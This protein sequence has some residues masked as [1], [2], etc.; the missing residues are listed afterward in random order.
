MSVGASSSE[1]VPRSGAWLTTGS[2]IPDS[3]RSAP[4][5]RS[6]VV[7]TWADGGAFYWFA[8]DGSFAS[9][10]ADPDWPYFQGF[11]PG[12]AGTWAFRDGR[13]R[14]CTHEDACALDRMV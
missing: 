3:Q 9:Y 5:R 7:G 2:L 10:W 8:A 12:D 1:G 13:L 14:S 6:D 11:E 4:V